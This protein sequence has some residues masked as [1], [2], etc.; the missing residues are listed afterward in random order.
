MTSDELEKR[1]D[2]IQ[3]TLDSRATV[4]FWKTLFGVII[5]L[6]AAG[7]AFMNIEDYA[8]VHYDNMSRGSFTAKVIVKSGAS[9]KR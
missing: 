9:V 6:G 2:K 5:V 7:Y 4:G 8:I 1:L 3:S